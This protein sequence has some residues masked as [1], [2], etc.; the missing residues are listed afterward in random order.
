MHNYLLI[1]AILAIICLVFE[2]LPTDVNIILIQIITVVIMA[3]CLDDTNVI[4]GGNPNNT[5]DII[6]PDIITPVSLMPDFVKLT[7]NVNSKLTNDTKVYYIYIDTEKIAAINRIDNNNIIYTSINAILDESQITKDI[8]SKQVLKYALAMYLYTVSKAGYDAIVKNK[9]LFTIDLIHQG[10]LSDYLTKALQR[11][12]RIKN[13]TLNNTIIA[14]NLTDHFEFMIHKY[15]GRPPEGENGD[16]RAELNKM[17]IC[18]LMVDSLFN[19]LDDEQT[20]KLL[21]KIFVN[22]IGEMELL[23]YA[24]ILYAVTSINVSYCNR[25]YQALIL[26]KL[27]TDETE[28][29]K[30]HGLDAYLRDAMW[31]IPLKQK[32][33][34]TCS[35]L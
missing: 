15:E 3:T 1:L 18:Q 35:I 25:K 23:R 8:F 27:P 5:P 6:T 7:D 31:S 21:K 13:Y 14:Y 4:T 26:K 32:S 20:N 12:N 30:I 22:N 2:L 28:Y 10:T 24:S 9:Q 16:Y 29:M 17:Q 33:E 19:P 11:I 34:R